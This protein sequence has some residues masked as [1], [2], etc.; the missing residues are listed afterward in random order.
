[1]ILG[2]GIDAGG[3]R[4]RWAMARAEG[5][6][7][8]SGEAGGMSALLL[9][10]IEGRA[11][12]KETL[13]GI[14]REAAAVGRP[15][16]VQAGVTGLAEDSAELRALVGEA[17]GLGA[18]AVTVGNDIV[19]AYL[20]IFQPEEGYVVYAGTGSVAAFVDGQGMLHRAGG[21]GSILDDGGSGFW[22]AREALRRIWR[23]E[24]CAPGVWRDSPLAVEVFARLGGSEWPRTRE[25]VYGG[26]RG[27]VGRLAMA[28]A[29]VAE[30]DAVARDI[31]ER[32][33]VEL[34]RLGNAMTSRFGAR[35][36]ALT[37]RAAL[38]HPAIGGAMR[39]ALSPGTALQVRPSEAHHAAA[40]LAAKQAAAISPATARP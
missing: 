39:S 20:G 37:G 38:L 2:L 27:Q 1:M 7:A 17:F 3:T 25:A 18:S 26:D 31:L 30:R 28:V 21:R 5:E 29:A 34:A 36:I 19:F 35:P 15:A 40:R 11:R 22:I 8:A 12:L 16:A 9:G 13:D 23:N 10:S 32:A 14:A 6:I 33:G 4:T 24:D